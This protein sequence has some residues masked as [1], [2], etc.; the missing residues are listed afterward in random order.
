MLLFELP[1]RTILHTGDFRFESPSQ[2][3]FTHTYPFSHPPCAPRPRFTPRLV[4]EPSVAGAL[5]RGPLDLLCVD[6]TFAARSHEFPA[7]W[8]G[9]ALLAYLAQRHP[10]HAL[11]LGVHSLGKEEALCAAA[12]AARS[13]VAVTRERYRTVV[14]CGFPPALFCPVD[15]D[16]VAAAA[17]GAAAAA[18]ATPVQPAASPAQWPVRIACV[19]RNAVRPSQLRALAEKRGPVLAILLS[20]QAFHDQG[21]VLLAPGA[22]ASAS[23]K[24]QSPRPSPPRHRVS[25]ATA[26]TPPPA[27]LSQDSWDGAASAA[28]APTPPRGPT[29]AHA[30]PQDV[31]PAPLEFPLGLCAAGDVDVAAWDRASRWALLAVDVAYSARLAHAAAADGIA[32]L[33]PAATAAARQEAREA[34]AAEATAAATCHLA[35]AIVCARIAESQSAFVHIPYSLHSS[36]AD[37]ARSL[38]AWPAREVRPASYDAPVHRRTLFRLVASTTNGQAAAV[39]PTPPRATL[40]LW[41]HLQRLAR[42]APEPTAEPA[43]EPVQDTGSGAACTATATSEPKEP[44]AVADLPVA[45]PAP[46]AAVS[47]PAR[48]RSRKR[49]RCAF[50]TV[51]ARAPRPRTRPVPQEASAAPGL[52]PANAPA[53]A[54]EG[55][56]ASAGDETTLLDLLESPTSSQRPAQPAVREEEKQEEEEGRKERTAVHSTGGGPVRNAAAAVEEEGDEGSVPAEFLAAVWRLAQ[57]RASAGRGQQCGAAP[58][59]AVPTLTRPTLHPTSLAEPGRREGGHPPPQS[60]Q[61]AATTLGPRP[62]PG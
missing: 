52:L 29:A 7:R 25:Q 28:A 20:G 56:A 45:R 35:S 38:A 11:L 47:R 50:A 3:R 4:R 19:L 6:N 54:G 43:P 60:R 49:G 40:S 22:S 5:R 48:R 44:T 55:I 17:A 30:A 24:A 8:T 18:A 37:L 33:P 31:K 58:T 27:S 46:A 21:P 26:P 23:A 42:A 16:P 62:A 9:A 39:P 15:D 10:R 61:G 32:A 12:F 41:R 1:D 51:P 2:P 36:R 34:E 59:E 14:M 13:R 57:Q 53:Q